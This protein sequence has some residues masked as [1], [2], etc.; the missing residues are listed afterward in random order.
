MRSTYLL[1]PLIILGSLVAQTTTNPDISVIGELGLTQF[2]DETTLN[3]SSVEIAIQGYVNPYA[4]ADVYLHK[5]LDE[6]P[7]ELEEAVLS[8][9]RGIPLGLALRAGKFRPEFGAI[10]KQHAHQFPQIILPVPVAHLLGDHKWSSAGLELNWLLPLPWYNNLSFGYLQDG[11]ST[12]DHAHEEEHDE[13]EEEHETVGKA[14][15]TRYSSFIDLGDVTHME[16]GISYYQLL[17]DSDINMVALDLK[18]KWRPNKF[19]SLTWQNELLRSGPTV[20]IE[21]GETEEHHEVVAAYSM[22][23][24]QFNKVWNAGFILDYSSDIEEEVYQS[25][26]LFIGFSP[27]EESTMLRIF[28]K[29]AKHGDHNEGFLLQAQLLWS[30]GPHKTHKF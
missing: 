19:Q 18:Y 1:L 22:L 9:E 10:N 27:V 23:N 8:I 30:L 3:A 16:F 20:H 21:D 13:E 28:A 26:G 7:I 17:E 25:G 6:H 14:F 2:D 5:H 29:Q 15:S 11:I 24:Y 4:R 12:E